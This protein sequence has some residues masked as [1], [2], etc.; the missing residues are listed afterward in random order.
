MVKYVKG[1]NYF[2]HLIAKQALIG[3]IFAMLT[4]L[5]QAP[6]WSICKY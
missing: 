3:Q 4:A 1:S 2:P 5:G 6:R